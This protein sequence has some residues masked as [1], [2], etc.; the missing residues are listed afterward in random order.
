[1]TSMEA[2][3]SDFRTPLY[4][5]SS[6][7]TKVRSCQ[8]Q[9]PCLSKVPA[10]GTCTAVHPGEPAMHICRHEKYLANLNET[11]PS[12]SVSSLIA[13]KPKRSYPGCCTRMQN[14]SIS[15]WAIPT[16]GADASRSRRRFPDSSLIN[17]LQSSIQLTVALIT[18]IVDHVVNDLALCSW[19][20]GTWLVCESDLLRGRH[21]CLAEL[22][23]KR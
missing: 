15:Q 6:L 16:H 2:D 20:A 8:N 22:R 19:Q 4:T 23:A 7:L 17:Q 9:T 12:L 5:T 1:M 14:A 21:S 18:H 11:D 10:T 13:N 3:V